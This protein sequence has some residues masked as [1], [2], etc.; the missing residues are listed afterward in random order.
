MAAIFSAWRARL[1]ERLVPADSTL[2]PLIL[3]PGH[4]PSQEQKCL[5]VAKRLRSGRSRSGSSSP[6]VTPSPLMRVRS[7][8]AQL[9]SCWRTSN[10]ARALLPARGV[11]PRST[12]PGRALEQSLQLGVALA[13]VAG[14]VVVHRQ[15]LLEHEQVLLAPVARQRLGDV[16]LAGLD[17]AV[18]VR[19]STS[20]R[21]RRP[22]CRG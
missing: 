4:K 20:G 17:A 22:R 6:I 10:S 15:R 14:N 1:A 7:T 13:Q 9:A 11:L 5:T 2:P 8:P 19:A 12:W 16:L 3:V 18:A 21:A